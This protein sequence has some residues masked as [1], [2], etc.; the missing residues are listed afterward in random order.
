MARAEDICL[1]GRGRQP[2]CG[3]GRFESHS[4]HEKGTCPHEKLSS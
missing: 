4:G 1:R 2:E 3:E